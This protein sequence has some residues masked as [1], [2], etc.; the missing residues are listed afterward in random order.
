MQRQL[1]EMDA[2]E[3]S[4]GCTADL[5]D[6]YEE[7]EMDDEEYEEGSF[8]SDP[9]NPFNDDPIDMFCDEFEEE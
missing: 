9:H 8:Y 2:D 1:S 5:D 7:D 4:S 3:Y 6:D